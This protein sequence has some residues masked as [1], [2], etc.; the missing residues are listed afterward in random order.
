MKTATKVVRPKPASKVS[1]EQKELQDISSKV[2]QDA[3]QKPRQYLKETT[4]PGG[5]E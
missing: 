4:S 2:R 3:L 1:P 5:G